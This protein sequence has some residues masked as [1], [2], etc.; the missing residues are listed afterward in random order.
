MPGH[1]R[2]A[3]NGA[4]GHSSAGVPLEAVIHANERRARSAELLAELLDPGRAHPRDPGHARRRILLHPLSQGGFAER[5]P[6]EEV[7]I[8]ET[9]CEQHVH[10]AERERG[11]GA[12]A[13][14]DPFVALRRRARANRI[15]G[16]HRR[17]LST[18]L[19]HEGP[20]VWIRRQRV[21]PPEQN[22]ITFRHSLGVGADVR[23]D[24]HSHPHR[25]RHRANRPIELRRTEE[26]EEAAIHRRAL[27]ESHRSGVRIGKNRLRA[28]ARA[29]D[30]EQSLRDLVERLVP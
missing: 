9:A 20:E 4:D 5:I 13:N 18:R 2:Q 24:R 7:P 29:L 16:D 12:G 10:H 26:V 23:A 19:E 27:D 3:G 22:E 11:V 25:T 1:R 15:D 17:P 30:V 8:F 28:V 14:G 21:R 6:R